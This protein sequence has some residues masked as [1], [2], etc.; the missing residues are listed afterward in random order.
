VSR[1][2]DASR[3]MACLGRYFIQRG[4]VLVNRSSLQVKELTRAVI[5]YV[6]VPLLVGF[7]LYCSQVPD[8]FRL[9]LDDQVAGGYVRGPDRPAG[10]S[11]GCLRYTAEVNAETA[12]NVGPDGVA[13]ACPRGRV[14]FQSYE[15]SKTRRSSFGGVSHIRSAITTSRW[16]KSLL[17]PMPCRGMVS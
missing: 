1:D 11:P 5:N 13:L 2:S 15:E 9:S 12:G 7:R 17:F 10:L 6:R 8:P 3:F 14:G 16:G 4:S